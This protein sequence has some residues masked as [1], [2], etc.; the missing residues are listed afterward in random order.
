MFR[1]AAG[2]LICRLSQTDRS[3]DNLRTVH[4]V[5]PAACRQYRACNGHLTSV[6]Y[7][8]CYDREEREL[9]HDCQN[10]RKAQVTFP[11]HFLDAMGVGP[12]DRLELVEGP[13]G[14]LLWP[15]E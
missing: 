1:R 2:I 15:S 7:L 10:H 8:L 12:G 6:L 11:T 9:R 5:K 13:D 4:R 3:R 14:Y